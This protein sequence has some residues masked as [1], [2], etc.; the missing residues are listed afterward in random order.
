MVN[1]TYT[2][3]PLANGREYAYVEIGL[4]EGS[5]CFGKRSL[6]GSNYLHQFKEGSAKPCNAKELCEKYSFVEAKVQE[7]L[8]EPLGHL[9]RPH[10]PRGQR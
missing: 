2:L 5:I 10:L 9:S 6:S 7:W 1:G 3:Q 8:D 4:G